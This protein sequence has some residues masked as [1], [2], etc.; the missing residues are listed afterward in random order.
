[1]PKEYWIVSGQ[2]LQGT[3]KS[4][5]NAQITQIPT[6]KCSYLL[7]VMKNLGNEIIS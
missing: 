3:G 6:E 2:F 4:L 1:M 5:G 7:G